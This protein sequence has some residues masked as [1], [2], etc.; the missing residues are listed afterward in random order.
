MK[1]FLELRVNYDYAHLL[2]AKN[3]GKDLGTSVRVV[4]LSRDDPRF[5]QVPIIEAEVRLKYG[6]GFFFGWEIKRK[7][8]KE[9]LGSTK[10]FNI[11]IKKIFEPTGEECGTLY[12]ETAMCEICGANRTQIGA[13]YLKRGKIPKVDI[14]C[15]IGG[16]LIVSQKFVETVKR[17]NLSGMM[18]SEVYF[19]HDLANY[20]QITASNNIDLSPNTVAGVDPFDFSEGNEGRE[21]TISNGSQVKFE[22]EIYKCPK[23][24]TIGLN[25]LSEAYVINSSALYEY[26]FLESRQ[27]IG[28]TRGF[29]RPEPI[30]FCSPSF[31][32]MVLEEKLTGFDFE[33]AKIDS[34]NTG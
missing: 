2:F 20:Y 33:I 21:F 27:K 5:E 12:D 26:D 9:E 28:V 25:L 22:K 13:L 8:S 7:Y 15:T 11:K 3:E 30:Y 16:E 18:F 4:Q 10:I 32:M 1:E 19:S 23:G 6:R 34:E 29:L 14:A 31:R 24:H 17:R